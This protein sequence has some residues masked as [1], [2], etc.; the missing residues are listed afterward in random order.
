MGETPMKGERKSDSNST[1]LPAGMSVPPCLVCKGVISNYSFEGYVDEEQGAASA[2]HMKCSQSPLVTRLLKRKGIRRL[3]GRSLIETIYG[4]DKS[5]I[6]SLDQRTPEMFSQLCEQ[7]LLNKK[8]MVCGTD[9]ANILTPTAIAMHM[10]K[11]FSTTDY[12]I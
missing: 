5:G 3:D 12:S 4:S 7:S 6:L 8:C 2:W 10:T 9:E 1:E 11:H